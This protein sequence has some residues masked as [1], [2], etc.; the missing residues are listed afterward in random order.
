[1][2]STTNTVI[3]P[4]QKKHHRTSSHES[5]SVTPNATAHQQTVTIKWKID[6][7]NKPPY[8]VRAWLT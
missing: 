4:N 6:F 8:Y 1:M 3:S 7:Q 2:T 5:N